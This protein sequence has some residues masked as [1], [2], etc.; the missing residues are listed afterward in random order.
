MRIWLVALA[1]LFATAAANAQQGR[2]EAAS[3][4]APALQLA[5]VDGKAYDLAQLKGR[6]VIVNFWAT[7]CGP[8]IA[9][10]PSLQALAAKLGSDKVALLGVNYHE[11]PQKITAF[12]RKYKVGFPLLRDAW[13]EASAAWKVKVLPTTFVIDATGTLRWRIVGEVDWSSRE[14]EQRL[15]E[16]LR[17]QKA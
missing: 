5:T 3:E 16:L 7:W 6:V 9:E 15:R 14:V 13:Q 11:S 10:M 17:P 1:L 2:W 8:C 4:A 12:Q